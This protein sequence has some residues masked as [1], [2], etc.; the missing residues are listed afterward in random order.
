[1]GRRRRG[2][3]LPAKALKRARR[4]QALASAASSDIAGVLAEHA[5]ALQAERDA[6]GALVE[7]AYE[8]AYEV[9]DES[10]IDAFQELGLEDLSFP[11]V[12]D[13]VGQIEGA[14]ETFDDRLSRLTSELDGIEQDLGAA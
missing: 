2:Q 13:L 1:M 11:D 14:L 6:F 4:I 12:E 9:D 8:N 10:G 3:L 5:A 7:N